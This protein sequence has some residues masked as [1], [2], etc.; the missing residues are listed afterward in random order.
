MNVEH[1]NYPEAKIDLLSLALEGAL[2]IQRTKE[3]DY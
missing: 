3:I 1:Q 2:P